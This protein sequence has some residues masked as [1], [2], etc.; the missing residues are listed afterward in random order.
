MAE[1]ATNSL[2]PPIA[3][4]PWWP[5]SARRLGLGFLAG[6]AVPLA[7]LAIGSGQWWLYALAFGMVFAFIPFLFAVVAYLILEHYGQLRLWWAV[8]VGAVLCALPDVV[9]SLT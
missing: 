6:V 9:I 5:G 8:L 4:S 7:I 1:M 3:L 2:R